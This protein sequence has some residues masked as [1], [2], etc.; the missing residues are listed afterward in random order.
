METI[1][2]GFLF[3]AILQ[4]A[5]LN[6]YDTIAGM[7]VLQDFSVAKAMGFSIGLG[8]LLM[9]LEIALGWADYHIKPMLLVGIIAGGILFGIGMAILGYCP[10]TIAISL[11]QGS[12]DALIGIFGGLCG[13]LAFS[14][15]YPQL[16]PLLGPNYG[17]I[18]LFTLMGGGTGFWLLTTLLAFSFMGL[19]W[20]LHQLQTRDLRWLYAAIALVLLNCALNLPQVAGHPM[21]ASTAF[22][23][24]IMAVSGW[25]AA[26]YFDKILEP[27]TWELWFLAGAFWAG[28]VF[29][30]ID[31]SFRLVAVPRLWQELRGDS[32]AQRFA[33]S[34]VGGFLLLFGARMAGGCTSGHVISGGM[35]FAISS[36]VF[37]VVV[38]AA[39]L[40]TG[41]IFYRRRRQ[42]LVQARPV[43]LS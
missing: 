43:P 20:Y 35:Q 38:F 7:A 8:L 39:F 34:F 9:Q 42:A 37:A 14:V 29:S 21:G 11:G 2:W 13:A 24:A 36:M 5:R 23:L 28:L 41:Q 40:G 4:Y 27:G 3:G 6:R 25:G 30:L 16:L 33:W 17:A 10:G 18:S 1:I 22:P 19:A 31:R 32:I 12:L 15:F 26:S